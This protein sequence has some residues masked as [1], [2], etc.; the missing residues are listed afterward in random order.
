MTQTHPNQT[1]PGATNGAGT[2]VVWLTQEAFDRLQA[3]LAQLSGPG[4]VEIARVIEEA[5]AEGDLRENGGYQAAREEQG[6][7]EGR[8]RQL[9][10]MLQRAKVG[11]APEQAGVVAPG[12][13]VTARFVGDEEVVTFILGSREVAGLDDSVDLDVYS[14]QSPLGTAV[15]GHAV[16]DRVTFTTPTGASMQV[17]ILDARPFNG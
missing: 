1:A 6:K 8:I 3:E 13:K 5:R 9:D 4:R 12:S 2:D 17:D 11:A 7:A 16:G 15:N 14:P 10:Q